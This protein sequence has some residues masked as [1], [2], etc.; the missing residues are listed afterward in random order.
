MSRMSASLLHGYFHRA[1]YT[2]SRFLL[3]SSKAQ[4][5]CCLVSEQDYRWS[6]QGKEEPGPSGKS[7]TCFVSTH[8][9]SIPEPS[10]LATS[11]MLLPMFFPLYLLIY[12]SRVHPTDCPSSCNSQSS[13]CTAPTGSDKFARCVCNSNYVGYGMS[14]WILS[15][16][17]GIRV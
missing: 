5:V 11:R 16:P 8:I 9:A 2:L 10:T 14:A 13:S 15:A 17:T 1:F 4:R 12:K 3:K 7:I 6:C